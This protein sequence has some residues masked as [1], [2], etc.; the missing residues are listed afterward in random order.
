MRPTLRRAAAVLPAAALALAPAMGR[1][2]EAES[3]GM[4]QFQFSNELTLAQVVWMVLI[5]LA[6]Y[7]LLARW[8]LP[9]LRSVLAERAQRIAAD[10]DAAKAAKADADAAVAELMAATRDARAEAQ[11]EIAAA[12]HA[13]REA[14]S[15]Q[16]AS[17][18][19][20]LEAELHEAEARI[21][22]ARATAMGAL[23]EVASETARAMIERLMGRPPQA[24]TLEAALASS[25]AATSS[26]TRG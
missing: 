14:A 10:L 6:L 11:A 19:A 15:R 16:A 25:L 20:R 18:N 5:F 23:R 17:L 4:P 22:A 13:A 12:A 2:A 26:S 7:F 1:A 24:S 9:Q 21:E 3:G 8:A